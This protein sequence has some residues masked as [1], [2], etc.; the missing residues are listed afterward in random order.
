[1]KHSIKL[2]SVFVLTTL[3]ALG[4]SD[5]LDINDDP[6]N[7]T[8][9]PIG[10]LLYQTTFETTRNTQRVGSTTSFFVQ[11]FASP[12]QASSTDIH[13]S[14]SYGGTWS[15]LYFNIGDLNEIIKQAEEEDSP[16]YSGVAKV[17]RAYNLGLLVNMF[18]DVPYSDAFSQES[19]QP[20]YDNSED[21]YENILQDLS[22][23]VTELSA[24]ESTASP[25]DGD[26]IYGGDLTAWTRTAYSLQARFLNH[27]SKLGNYDPTAVLEAVD[28]GF[29]G[30][31]EDFEME[32]FDESTASQNPW[33]RVAVNNADLLLGGWLSE[34][35]VNQL[36]GDTYGVEDP[37]IEFITEPVSDEEDPRFGE[38]VGT[39]NGAGRGEDPEQGVRAV[40]AVDSYYASGPTAPLENMTYAELKFIEAEA[41]LAA[42][43]QEARA[44]AAYEE[45]I[46]AH[47]EKLGVEQADID[48]YWSDPVVSV[49]S[50][51]LTIDE[52]M[53]EK[54]IA[55]FL[56]PE[57]WNDAR[58]YDYQYADFE[59]PENSALGGEMI[60]LVR[61]PDS[62]LQ[63]NEANVPNRSMT[64][65]VFWDAQ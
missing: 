62:E 58:R 56:N 34:Q 14:V 19:L 20:T 4:C 31:N 18:G 60:R 59:A 22:D 7:P 29:S 47:M 54:Y 8:S 55:T 45:G 39:R 13:E 15:N 12:N 42:G 2:L 25:S 3:M 48:A 16:H 44:Y 36:N 61:Y 53:K 52:I 28:N 46:R 26:M 57:T 10:A 43:G 64:D 30:N 27:Y 38:Y 35:T 6:N 49:G 50:A 41:A 17:L 21:I 33:Y 5:Y 11:H 51:N 24:T 1:M 63:R 37:R 32:F 40:L 23:A 9:A 65:R